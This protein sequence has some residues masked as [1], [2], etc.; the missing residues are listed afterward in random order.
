[1]LLII[2]I[3][4]W[5]LY[6]YILIWVYV[7]SY[8]LMYVLRNY[9]LMINYDNW[10]FLLCYKWNNNSMIFVKNNYNEWSNVSKKKLKL[11]ANWSVDRY[12][13]D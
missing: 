6:V 8:R 4:K 11:F 2:H 7:F 5:E 13:S 12:C 3:N 1:M 10:L 9:H